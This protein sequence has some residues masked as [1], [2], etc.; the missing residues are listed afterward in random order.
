[1]KMKEKEQEMQGFSSF[2]DSSMRSSP[3]KFMSPS[4]PSAMNP[5]KLE[6]LKD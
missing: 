2:K 6:K 4:K 1:M 5:D 3:K